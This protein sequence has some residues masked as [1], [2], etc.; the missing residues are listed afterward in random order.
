MKKII[1][2]I[3]MLIT[4]SVFAQLTSTEN[5]IQSKTYL[6]AVTTTSTTARQIET[7]QYFDGLGR[8]KQIVNVKASPLGRDVATKIEYDGFGRQTIDYLPVPQSG[9]QNGAIIPDP[10]ANAANT[11]YGS[12]KIYS[13]KILESSPLS[14]IQQQI[15]VGNDWAAKPVK[16]QYEVN[17]IGEVKKFVATT[18]WLN[19]EIQSQL[20]PATDPDSENGNYK[21]GQLYKNVVTDEDENKTIEFKN[22]RGQTIL[23]RKVLSA[24]ENADTYYVYNE[25]DQLAFVIPPL[26]SVSGFPDLSTLDKLCYQYHYD[27]RNRLVEKKLPGKGWEYMVY[28]KTDRLILTQDANLKLQNKWIITKYDQLGRVAYTG[29]LTTGGGR[30]GRQNEINNLVI[31]EERSTTG[32]TRNGMT[33]YYTDTYFV[34][35]VQT[36]L[37]VNYYDTY[38]QGSPA[39]NNQFSEALLTDNMAQPRNTKGLPLASYVKNIEDDNWTKTFTW[40]DTRGRAIETHSINHLGGYTRTESKL[41]FA[42]VAQNTVT[43]HLRRVGEPE[44]TVKERFNYDSQNRLLKHYHQVDY[45]PEQLLVENSYNE[46]SQLKNKVV[47]GNLQSIDY[48]Y[49]I[50]GWMTDINPAQMSLPDLG[51][52]L[53]TYK[54]KYNQKNGTTNPDQ[55]QFPGK[56]VKPMYNGNI[57]EV[58]WRAVE[59]LGA[60]PPLEPKRYGYAYDGLNRLTAGYYQNPNNPWSKENTEVMDYDINGNITNMYRTSV[61]ENNTTATLIDKLTY[62]YTGNKL[63]SINDIANNPSGYEGGGNTITYDPN[64]N[65]ENMVDK[66]ITSIKYNFLNLPERMEISNL[67]GGG[68]GYK[69]AADGTKLQ[70]IN[71]MMECGIQ[72]CYTVNT[73]SD[74]LDGFQYVSRTTTGGGSTELLVASRE[75]SK[76]M[77]VQAYSLNGIIGPIDPGIDPP[78]GGGI[79]GE[80]KDENLVFFPIAEGYYDYKKDQYIYQYKDHLGNV[81]ISFGRN[82]AGALEIVDANDYYPFGMNHLKT[83][84]AFYG[85]GSYKNYKYNGKELQETGMYDYGAR[86]YMADLGRWGVV[87]PLA[88]KMTRYS[89]YNYAFNNPLRFIDPDGRQAKDWIKMVDR[90]TNKTTVT[91]DPN[92]TTAAQ[93]KDANYKNVD[94]VGKTGEITNSNGKV[95]HTLNADGSVTNVAENSS[96]YGSSDIGG[97]QVNAA[98]N[99]GSFWSFSANFA[100]GGGAGFSFGQVTDS[101]KETDF[102]FSLN[103]NLG[104]SAS[105]GFEK[106]LITPTDSGHKFVN[107]DF[108]GEGRAISGGAGPFSSSVGGTFNRTKSPT[109]ALIRTSDQFNPG[110]FGRNS[111]DFKAGYTTISTSAGSGVGVSPV[112][113]TG[114]KTWVRGK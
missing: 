63:T 27:G 5:Y 65:M 49:N 9:T 97:V 96:T 24:T 32:F 104:L 100:F 90:E 107:S 35:E 89:P 43:R 13:E 110:S 41:H 66:K 80:V 92:I 68:I 23:V 102:F 62:N 29:F 52:K 113:W 112:M 3:G 58:D 76:A 2:P 10:L 81:R 69:Y 67:S 56:N 48:A 91:Y 55:A 105:A 25:Y 60:N 57:V 86:M 114:S 17:T 20:N 38:P 12:E 34:G 101:N 31:A 75:M 82:S 77:E 45:W 14:R 95:T 53:F 108:V 40:Y 83:G 26:A 50:R 30:V 88:E 39:A 33:V 84:N 106:G 21:A 78:I 61:L 22:G 46:L 72:N 37:S 8:P 64:G 16:F 54:I 70:K 47:G 79:I 18:S 74:Y 93:A 99:T 109:N 103:G 94:S 1:I 42:G 7:V 19:G 4:Q 73:I 85:Q 15:Q 87:D 98:D 59:S 36:I 51:G 111:A 11:P 71:S 6:E 44:V 28:D